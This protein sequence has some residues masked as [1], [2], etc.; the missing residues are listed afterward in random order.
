MAGVIGGYVADRFLGVRKALTIGYA[1]KTIGYFLLAIPGGGS[2]LYLGSQFMLLVSG[3]FMGTSLYALAGKLYEK[4]DDRRDGGFS[5]M[6]V[7]N[8]VG[9]VSP[10]ITGT[11]AQILNYHMGF[12]FA[13]VIQLLGWVLYVLTQNRVFGDT[14]LKP[15]DPVPEDKRGKSLFKIAAGVIAFV[16]CVI[17]M[18]TSGICTPTVFCNTVSIVSIFIPLAYLVYIYTSKKTTREEAVRIIP[19][20]FIFVANCFNMMIWNQSTTILAIYAAERVNMNF[21]GLELTPAAF[22]TV[23]AVLAVLFGTFASGL[24]TKLGDKQ[25]STPLKFGIGTAFWASG[26]L[27]MIIPFMLYAANVKV[28]PMWLMIFYVLVI[29]GEAMTSPVGMAASGKVAPVAFTAQMVTVWQL[30]QATGSGL[31][32]LSVT[33]YKQGSESAYFLGIGGVTLLIGVILWV[34]SRKLSKL[35]E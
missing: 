25:P 3:T 34:F 35:M 12:L 22:Q 9:A 31:S 8:N 5:I 7:M 29:W 28:S 20:V 16:A 13:A 14:G 17:V 33:F 10:I 1:V 11:I 26:P 15:D 30:S 27:F 4:G 24:W 18:L 23:P 19:F 2:I 32:A 6:Y 21:F